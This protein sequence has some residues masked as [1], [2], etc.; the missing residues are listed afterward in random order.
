MIRKSTACWLNCL[1]HDYIWLW[2]LEM[3][4][5]QNFLL[6]FA[7]SVDL[8]TV[9]LQ[10]FHTLGDHKY[11]VWVTTEQT[12][13]NFRIAICHSAHILLSKEPFDQDDDSALDIEISRPDGM[14]YIRRFVVPWYY[15]LLL[16][17]CTTSGILGLRH[18]CPYW[19]PISI[20][21]IM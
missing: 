13:L 14:S 4:K 1:G 7:G 19:Q 15:V 6:W 5:K 21:I 17:Y 10:T 2:N 16:M 12:E 9:E 3:N 8:D 18:S 20:C 11:N